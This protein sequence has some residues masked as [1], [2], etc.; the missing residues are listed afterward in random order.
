LQKR[1]PAYYH[2]MTWIAIPVKLVSIIL[3]RNLLDLDY[4]KLCHNFYAVI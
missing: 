3:R 1:N 4:G 2:F